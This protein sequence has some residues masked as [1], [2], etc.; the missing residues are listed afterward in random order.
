MRIC[1]TYSCSTAT[2]VARTGLNITL[3]VHCLYCCGTITE[4][5]TSKPNPV[6]GFEIIHILCCSYSLHISLSNRQPP[7]G[8]SRKPSLSLRNVLISTWLAVLPKPCLLLWPIMKCNSDCVRA[9][10]M[11]GGNYRVT[12][13]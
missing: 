5:N 11:F 9:T 6:V 7:L 2:T 3:Y 13:C 4:H 1:N 10:N 12:Q 8:K